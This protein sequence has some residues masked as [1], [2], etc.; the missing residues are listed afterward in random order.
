MD[1][2]ALQSQAREGA[3][4]DVKHALE[5]GGAGERT[6]REPWQEA[7]IMEEMAAGHSFC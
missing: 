3:S 1:M 7:L 4:A 6:S 2:I 5:G